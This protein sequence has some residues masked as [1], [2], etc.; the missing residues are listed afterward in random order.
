[1]TKQEYLSK[2]LKVLEYMIGEDVIHN[3]FG[4]GKIIGFENNKCI[5][6]YERFQTNKNMSTITFFDYHEPVAQSTI[7]ELNEL[8]CEYEMSKKTIS[9]NQILN[10]IKDIGVD[11]KEFI[12]DN[13]IRFED[14]IGL[15]DV[16]DLVNQLIIYPFKYRDI[17]KAFKRESGGGILL[18]GAP[19]TGKTMIAKAIANEVDAKFIS[20]KCSD[21]VS[22]WYG[23]SEKKI[24]EFFNEARKYRRSII[25]FDEFDSLGIDREKDNSHA[26]NMVVSELLTQIDGFETIENT[27]LLIA[28]TNKPWNIDSALLRSGRFNKKIYVGL[29]NHKS[30]CD[31]LM[32]QFKDVPIEEIDYQV[33]ADK[34][35]GYSSADIVEL[36][37]E[38]KDIAIKRS[39]MNNEL[40]NITQDDINQALSQVSST[41]VKKE[42][43]KLVSFSQKCN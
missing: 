39:I 19:G 40:S 6:K 7:D 11:K 5:V 25:Y 9:Q 38:A 33:I 18:Y 15:D 29:P 10:A 2:Q 36:C 4:L 30:R 22:K 20:I 17:Y 37:N 12:N 35:E 43:D 41:I 8:K 21:I 32:Y 31:L 16:K 27:I 26:V 34:T 42:L 28:S 14:V 24:K 23:E 1:M 13:K 3:E